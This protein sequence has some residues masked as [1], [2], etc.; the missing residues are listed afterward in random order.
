MWSVRLRSRAVFSCMWRY[1]QRVHYLCRVAKKFLHP[2]EV[3][4]LLI[5]TTVQYGD[6]VSNT[7]E[8]D[9]SAFSL[10]CLLAA[11]SKGKQAVKLGCNKILQFLTE[12][13]SWCRLTGW[14][15]LHLNFMCLFRH[16]TLSSTCCVIG[17]L[18]MSFWDVLSQYWCI[19]SMLLWCV[20][21]LTQMEQ[22][23]FPRESS[24]AGRNVLLVAVALNFLQCF[25]TLLDYRND[26]QSVDTFVTFSKRFSSGIIEWES[27]GC[28]LY[29]SDAADE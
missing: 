28:L 6:V 19:V 20:G 13:A 10:I 24:N 9:S 12:A 22:C 23:S 18:R 25:D 8:A 17:I 7:S 1:S 27:C 26:I 14:C 11:I 29:T 16:V 5:C 4:N 2:K 15:V 3:I 21:D